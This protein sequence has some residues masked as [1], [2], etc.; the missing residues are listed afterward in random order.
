LG[1]EEGQKVISFGLRSLEGRKESALYHAFLTHLEKEGVVK[2]IAGPV[3]EL[4]KDE[5]IRRD[6]H[7]KTIR[8]QQKAIREGAGRRVT[9]SIGR[10]RDRK[11]KTSKEESSQHL[12]AR[13]TESAWHHIELVQRGTDRRL[14][15]LRHTLRYEKNWKA[16]LKEANRR[17][18]TGELT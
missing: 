2:K 5:W 3:A 11:T 14:K 7:R 13:A 17:K 12:D 4:R 1:E 15:K 9:T 8:T 6:C 18:V 10:F 16:N